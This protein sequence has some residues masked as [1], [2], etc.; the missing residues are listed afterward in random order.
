[1]SGVHHR[2]CSLCEAMCG[3]VIETE[4]GRIRS[5]RGDADDVFSRGH[6]CPKAV[7]LQDVHDDPDRIRRPLRRR[8]RDWEEISWDEALDE[9]AVRL[10]G[11]QRAHGRDTVGVYQGNPLFHNYGGVL[12][13]QMLLHTLSETRFSATSADQLPQMLSALLMFGHQVLLPIP[14]V[15]RT[16][17]FLA[18]GANPLASNG[19][20]MSAPG[21]EKRL[22]AMRAR[23][24]RL[25]VVDPRRTETA[26]IADLHVAIRPG[27]DALLLMALVHVLFAEG[28]VRPGHL[29]PLIDGLQTVEGLA[30]AFA[31]EAVAEPT[32]VGAEVIRQIARELSE[33]PAAICYGRIGVSTQEFGALCCW[34]INVLNVLTANLDRPGGVLF[35]RPAANM[36]GV[37]SRIGQRGSFATRHSR[38]RGLPEFGGEWP[39]AVLAEEIETEGPGRIRGL[40]TIAGNPALSAPN[41]RRLEGAL[42]RLDFMVSVDFHLNETTRH[43]HLI[44]P[45]ASPLERDHYDLIFHS[46]AVRNTSK[47]SPRLFAPPP[48]AREDWQ[49]LGQLA[50]RVQAV[51]GGRPL[52]RAVTALANRMGPRGILRLLL[53]FGPYGRGLRPFGE[54]LTLG[55]LERMPHGVDL[56]PLEPSLPR[57]LQ[58]PGRRIVLAPPPLVADLERLRAATT[59]KH[60]GLVLVGRRD[61]RSNNSWMHNSARLVK[62]RDRCTL[63]MHPA[64]VAARELVHGERVRVSSRAGAVEV[65]LEATDAMRP[66][67]VSLP[68]GWGHDR[69]GTRLAVAS[70][71]AG[72]SVNDLNDDRRVDALAGTAAFSGLPVEVTR[73]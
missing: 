59:R 29:A 12:F 2:T 46:L 25:V 16:S 48:G 45:P 68:H 57:A 65:V 35:T 8:G 10:T 64:D 24:G 15:D 56:G 32:G 26:A 66:G 11:L 51:R 49:I 70:S 71:R 23:G 36:V 41:G 34:L 60:D 7:A 39:V 55:A 61:L 20:L 67:V 58:T 27:T 1:V 37:A 73:L 22:R 21:I 4:G 6:I 72:V 9:A 47:Y 3:L 13:G 43:A 50:R 19:S 44:L 30:R 54:G 5:V 62:G 17:Y 53:R 63:L 40:V 69:P 33:A 28:R 14:D 42:A 18:L 52:E 31:P 38:V